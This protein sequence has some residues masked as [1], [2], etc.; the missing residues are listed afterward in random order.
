MDGGFLGFNYIK[1]AG[2][3]LG[4]DLWA[5]SPVNGFGQ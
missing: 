4:L 1:K 5:V 3:A 2:H